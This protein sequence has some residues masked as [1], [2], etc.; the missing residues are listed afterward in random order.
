V[1]LQ[2]TNT[3]G[4]AQEPEADPGYG[5]TGMTERADLAGGTVDAGPFDGG[6]RVHLRLP[7]LGVERRR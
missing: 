2:I 3:G 4:G 7:Y 6:F 5:L 1:D